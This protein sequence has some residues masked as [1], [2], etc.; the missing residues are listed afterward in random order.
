MIAGDGM[1]SVMKALHEDPLVNQEVMNGPLHPTSLG[2]A[3]YDADKKCHHPMPNHITS[4]FCLGKFQNRNLKFYDL[5]FER[6]FSSLY[7]GFI[8]LS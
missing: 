2:A 6:P 1:S 8:M 7:Y 3:E 5:E 4:T